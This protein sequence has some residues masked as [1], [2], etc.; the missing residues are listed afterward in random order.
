MVVVLVNYIAGIGNYVILLKGL[1][2]YVR[3]LFKCKK[4]IFQRLIVERSRVC[5]VYG[6]HV[7]DDESHAKSIAYHHQDLLERRMTE[8]DASGPPGCEGL[9]VDIRDTYLV[10]FRIIRES[11]T[12]QQHC[13]TMRI[14][15]GHVHVHTS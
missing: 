5:A 2:M 6:G 15:F 13:G 12:W 1:E 4:D 14:S 8:C 11:L 7:I 9:G 3:Y 10:A